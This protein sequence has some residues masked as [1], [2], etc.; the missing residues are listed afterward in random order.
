[1]QLKE[2][3]PG[4]EPRTIDRWDGGVGWLAH[5]GERMQRA[6]HALV[7]DDTV[8]LVDPVDAAGLDSILDEY[9]DVAGVVVLLD[10]HKR[11][12]GAL[13]RRY[14]VPVFVPTWMSGVAGAIDAPVERFQGTLAQTPYTSYKLHDNPFW[15]EAVLVD[16]DGGTL[17]VPE[18]VG[19][20]DYFLAEDERLG[21]HPLL[22]LFPP[23][24]LRQ[25]V[26]DRIL[27]GHG[28]GIHAD[29]EAQLEAALDGARRRTPALYLQNLR[30]LLRS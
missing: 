9:G 5:P 17:V 7:H 24:A 25:F 18:S 23:Q 21:V 10:R 27:V 8:W 20:V 11:D 4:A 2:S 13:A 3:G 14:D 30:A 12:A 22:R 19:T 6:S 26:P 16:D 29:A 28:E 15:Q 1:M